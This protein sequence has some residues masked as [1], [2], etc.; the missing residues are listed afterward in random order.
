MIFKEYDQAIIY[1]VLND[2]KRYHVG[3]NKSAGWIL[4]KGNKPI[5]IKHVEH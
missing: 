3:G 1:A 5:K 2:I 4:L